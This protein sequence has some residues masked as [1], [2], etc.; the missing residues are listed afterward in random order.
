MRIFRALAATLL[1]VSS[2]ASACEVRKS[3]YSQLK[4]G[5][6]YYD[7]MRLLACGGVE[8]SS[9]EIGSIKTSM[10]V[11]YGSKDGANL[12]AMFQNDKLI[13]KVQIGLE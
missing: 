5:M 8:M 13:S 10:Y 9:S 2:S 6:Q 11:W 3:Q 12:T 4:M 7:V 1:L